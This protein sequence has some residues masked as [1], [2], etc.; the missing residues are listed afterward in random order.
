MEKRT[1]SLFTS[2]LFLCSV[3]L[4][5]RIMFTLSDEQKATAAMDLIK[6]NDRINENN[7]KAC[8]ANHIN[9]TLDEIQQEYQKRQHETQ[10]NSSRLV[11]E[12]SVY[13]T[14]NP[15]NIKDPVMKFWVDNEQKYKLLRP[16]VDII[17]AV[18]SN[19]CC[20]ERA[21]SSFS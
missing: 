21:F 15:C 4:D 16:L 5:P 19:Q 1:P 17:H 8:D 18:P 10:N 2:P 7:S 14:E 11:L 12:C 6:I 3:Y 13:E 20:T 9:D